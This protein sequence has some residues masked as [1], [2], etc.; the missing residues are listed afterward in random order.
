MT[1]LYSPSTRGFYEIE[2]HGNNIPSDAV[3]VTNEEYID[4]LATPILKVL[5]VQEQIVELEAQQTPRRL[6]EAV[7]TEDGELWL[8]SIEAQITA[9]RAQL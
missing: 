3:Q 7:L 2:I 1:K 5:T 4:I 6:R 8:T 9:L